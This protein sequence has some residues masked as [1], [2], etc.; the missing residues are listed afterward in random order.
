[1]DYSL[2]LIKQTDLDLE[3]AILLD[4]VQKHKPIS[5]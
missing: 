1:M 3:T 2:M 5:A 4:R